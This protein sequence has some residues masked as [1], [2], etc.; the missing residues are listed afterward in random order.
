M[1]RLSIELLSVWDLALLCFVANMKIDYKMLTDIMNMGAL[2]EYISPLNV[3]Y[4]HFYYAHKCKGANLK[5][6]LFNILQ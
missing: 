2:L 4:I 5:Y 1:Y 3:C 6:V